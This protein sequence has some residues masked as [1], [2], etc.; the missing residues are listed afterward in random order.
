MYGQN[1]LTITAATGYKIV[2]IELTT[3]SSKPV[4]EAS[5]SVTGGTFVVDSSTKTTITATANTV[6]LKNTASSGHF[7]VQ[8]IKVV[9]EAV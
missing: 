6:E 8:S 4:V 5:C 9:Y 2:S 1:S 3:D 7:R